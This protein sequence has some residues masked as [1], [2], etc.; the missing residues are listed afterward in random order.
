MELR[1]GSAVTFSN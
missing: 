1:V